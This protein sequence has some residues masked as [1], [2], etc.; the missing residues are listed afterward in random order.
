MRNFIKLVGLTFLGVFIGVSFAAS[1]PSTSNDADVPVSVLVQQEQRIEAELY[2][3]KQELKH[4]KKKTSS[5]SQKSSAKE[6]GDESDLFKVSSQV[7]REVYNSAINYIGG[8]TVTT[9]PILGLK[10]AWNASDLLYQVSSMNEDLSLLQDRDK[11]NEILEEYSGDSLDMRPLVIISGGIEA[12]ASYTKGYTN[13]DDASVNLSTAEIDL[14]AI[15]SQWASGF[16]A[17]DYDDSPPDTGSRVTNSRLFLQR[18][19]VTVGNLQHAPVYLTMGQIFVPFGRYSSA[20]VT[21]PLTKTIGRIEDRALVL[22]YFKDGVYFQAYGDN[23]DRVDSNPN[24][25]I[26]QGGANFGY[27][28]SGLSIGA[29][30]VGVGYTTNLADSQ[31]MQS[32]GLSSG[33]TPSTQFAGFSQTTNADGISANDLAHN[34]DALDFHWS[35]SRGI[36]TLITEYITALRRFDAGDLS[37]NGEGAMVSALQTELD[38][39]FVFRGMPWTVGGA[40]N[41]SWQALALNVPEESYFAV[42]STSFWKNT[43]ESV[44]FRHDVNYSVTGGTGG[45]GAGD[46]SLDLPVPDANV[47][48]SQDRITFQLGAYF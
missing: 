5:Q 21:T 16:M 14:W 36:M 28:N 2:R 41:R 10:S 6:A 40:Y 12:T 1:S 18:G 31:G 7:K 30:D 8:I 44:E 39:N 11:F 17:I 26:F 24:G 46:D 15:M 27:K 33:G 45:G 22:G 35:L 20:V 37:F 19:F 34:V 47:G 13:S 9:S 32:N 23:G 3:L 38:F 4:R 48:G 43:V 42:V 25:V 29:I